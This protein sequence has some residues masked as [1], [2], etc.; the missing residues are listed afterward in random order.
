MNAL[1][2]PAI[3]PGLTGR[4]RLVVATE[5]LAVEEGDDRRPVFS[6]PAMVALA[7]RAAVGAIDPHLRGSWVCVGTEVCLRHLAPAG[8]GTTI[9]ADAKL[10]DRDGNTLRFDVEVTSESK[11][12]GR[13]TLER[14]LVDLKRFLLR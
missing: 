2:F 7:E 1:P 4:A 11:V 9:V 14:H 3:R 5:H 8:P 6:T 13:G 10:T 12:L